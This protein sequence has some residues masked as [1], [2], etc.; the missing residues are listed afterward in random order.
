MMKTYIQ[1]TYEQRCQISI[2]IRIG[3]FQQVIADLVGMSQSTM[4]RELKRNA[5]QRGYR[6]NQ[7]QTKS[8]TR[9][10][11]AEKSIKMTPDMIALIESKLKAK[12][13]S[14]QISGW[15]FEGK[16]LRISYE[17]IHLYRWADKQPGGTLFSHLRPN[18]N[19]YQPRGNKHAG[20]GCIK[21]R[22]SIDERPEI[23]EK[24][25]RIGDWEL[26]LVIG[27]GQRAKWRAG[28]YC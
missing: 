21:N 6:E 20:R 3:T 23:V 11:K 14:E 7:A 18:G 24:K 1:L 25:A 27:K 4:S 17:T 2:L 10:Q 28:H 16:G 12:W 13:S 19:A 22:V 9:R 26:D 5:G 8:N 15:V